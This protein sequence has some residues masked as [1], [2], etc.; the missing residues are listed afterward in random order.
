[1]PTADH[2]SVRLDKWSYV[3]GS[4]SV[5]L[6]GLLGYLAGG[7]AGILAAFAGLIPP[8]LWQAMT[9][10]RAR[11]R[12][13]RK[14]LRI[15]GERFVAPQIPLPAA[16][17][18]PVEDEDARPPGSVLRYL[19]AEAEI[20]AFRARPELDVLHAWAAADPRVDVH[21]VVG[22]GGA[23]KTRLALQLGNELSEA[24][25][26]RFYWVPAGAEADAVQAALAEPTPVL[27]VLD[28]AET[29]PG[30]RDALGQVITST[31]AAKVRVLLL[32]RGAGEWWLQL[33]ASAP[34]VVSETLAAIQPL[35]LGPLT[36]P[37]GQHDV[38]RQALQAFAVRRGVGCPDTPM[39]PT[40]GPSVPVLVVHAAALVA[41]LDH[42]HG[43]TGGAA[44]GRAGLIDVLLRH[45][46]R[47]WQQTQA[48]YSLV[49][50]PALARRVIAAGTLLGA[51]DEASADL[52]LSSIGELAEAQT[53][54]RAARWLHDLYP[55]D[56]GTAG[57]REWIGALRPDLVAEHLVV[58]VLSG[59]PRLASRLLDGQDTRRVGRALT[60]MGRAALTDPAA[61][62]LMGSLLAAGSGQLTMAA[63]AVATETNP[64]VGDLL[65]DLLETR[66]WPPEVLAQIAAALPATTVALAQ[67]GAVTYQRLADASVPGS[68]DQARNLVELSSYAA[69]MGR[70]EDA[71]AAID[72]A[73]TAYRQLADGRPDAFLPDLAMA[74]SNQSNRLSDLGRREDALA[75]INEATTAYRQLAE[76]RPDVFLP[77]LAAALNNQA[78]CLSGLGRR[79]DAQAI[80]DEAVAIRRQLAA[81][82][83]DAFLPD[84]A[85]ALNNQSNSLSGL[86]R[87]EDALAAI[88]EATTAYR[89]LAEARPDAFLPDLAAA[90]NNQSNSLSGLG[91]RENAL[92]AINEAVAIR[93]Q[94][95]EARPDAFLPDLATALN[96][97]SLRLS[98]LGRRED[99]LAAIDEAV[100][101]RRQLAA[102]Q[103]EAFLPDLAAALTNQ[104]MLLFGLGHGEDAQAAI[105][106]AVTIHRELAAA[107]PDAFLP[108]LATALNNQSNCLS[109][110]GRRE[111]ALAAI[112]EAV[113]IRRQLALPVRTRSWPSWPW[114]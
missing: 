67:T 35:T 32:A 92:A 55:P 20:V 50:G 64:H 29:R 72:D 47:Y 91:R 81:A 53:R 86:G 21:L 54:A 56:Q 27:L 99:G 30:I 59:Q 6:A 42:E 84:L 51:D 61:W 104:T 14:L 83:P 10:R 9:E 33:I 68:E 70:R 24:S 41:V 48:Q 87:R 15:A 16:D 17:P 34:M 7:R 93:R 105:D 26:W 11:T 88:N 89:Q 49:L 57:Q 79:E 8:V 95:A 60:V 111:D 82:R 13:E 114:R 112:D 2:W 75:A 73:V 31:E 39:P 25:R 78:R 52:L 97:Q 1:M 36:D 77:D 28:Y 109:D 46:E 65:A 106:E 45:E 110:L 66:E 38:Y 69:Q 113:T 12:A 101:I 3:I 40:V 76:A 108:N 58:A 62:D 63:L 98:D 80:I 44:A 85:M 102:A 23:G 19:R 96:N 22:E 43:V 5:V 74:L 100:T 94:L 103:P 107:R 90:L 18:S 4:A 37:A 71:L